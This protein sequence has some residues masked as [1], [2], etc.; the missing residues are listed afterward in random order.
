MIVAGMLFTL[1]IAPGVMRLTIRTDGH[2]LVPS[3]APEIAL[4]REIRDA[5]RTEDP[6]IILI[7]TDHP[8]GLFNANTL[9]TVQRLTVALSAV[10]GVR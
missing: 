9:N 6:I 1:A 4:D 7:R 2:A 5:F 10:D 3:Y 8:D